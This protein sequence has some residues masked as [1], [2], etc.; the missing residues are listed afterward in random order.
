M[1]Q[2]IQK[3]IDEQRQARDNA[4]EEESLND[5]RN[6]VAYLRASGAS[7]LELMQAEEELAAAEESY[8]D[9]LVDQSIAK[10]ED[11][12]EKAASQRE[13]QINLL[14]SQ[15]EFWKETQNFKDEVDRIFEESRMIIENGGS[16]KD[17]ELWELLGYDKLSEYE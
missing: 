17:T 16:I 2:A 5:M 12:N 7:P 11:A 15:L 13:E 10:L 6:R 8:S 3:Q 9:K 14:R 4:K 1:V